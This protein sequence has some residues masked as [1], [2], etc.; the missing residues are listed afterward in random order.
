MAAQANGLQNLFLE[1]LKDIYYA[2]HKLLLALP[3]MAEGAHTQEVTDAFD[4]HLTETESQVQRLEQVFEMLGE[5]AKGKDCPAIDGIIA[6]AEEIL[7]QYEGSASVDAG[8]VAAAHAVEHY[9]IA[10]Y[11]TLVAWAGLLDMPEAAELLQT[12]LEE[13]T[14]TDE[15]LTDLAEGGINEMALEADEDEGLEQVEATL[16][17]AEVEG[18]YDSDEQKAS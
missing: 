7:E 16:E 12:T 14:A 17:E 15:A 11:G 6:E 1:G 9:E 3:K 10:R 8:L 18:V 2:E 4:L 13:E 5:S